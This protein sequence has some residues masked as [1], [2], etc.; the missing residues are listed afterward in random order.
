MNSVRKF[1]AGAIVGAALATGVAGAIDQVTDRHRVAIDDRTDRVR[2]KLPVGTHEDEW[3]MDY[4]WRDDGPV[5]VVRLIH[6]DEC[7]G[8]MRLADRKGWK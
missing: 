1:V 2:V 5:L 6:Q 7:L 4:R 8:W 3:C